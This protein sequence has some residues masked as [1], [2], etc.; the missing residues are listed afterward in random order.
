M[1]LALFSVPLTLFAAGPTAQAAGYPSVQ[2]WTDLGATGVLIGLV[3]WLV[4]KAQPRE[5]EASRK[6]LREERDE[7]R[8]HTE[9]IVDKVCDRFSESNTEVVE[10][11][12]KMSEAN[13]CI[14]ANCA[15]HL[16]RSRDEGVPR[17]GE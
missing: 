11:M 3:V 13:Q 7:S 15:A 12:H 17:D 10:A 4:T 2:A 8:A 1:K 9:K 14:A 5:R 16:G 6:E